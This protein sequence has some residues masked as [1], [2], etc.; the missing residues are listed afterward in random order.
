[1]VLAI[2]LFNLVIDVSF[3]IIHSIIFSV[4]F[5]NFQ[6]CR[7]PVLAL[8]LAKEEAIQGWRDLLGPKEV[9]KAKEESPER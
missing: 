8:G 2:H 4:L 7:G 5:F 1:M 3:L 6:I 9:Q